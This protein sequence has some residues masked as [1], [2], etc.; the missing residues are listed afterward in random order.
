MEKEINSEMETV[1]FEAVYRRDTGLQK[2]QYPIEDLH[3]THLQPATDPKPETLHNI[4]PRSLL[5]PSQL[6]N[7]K[8]QNPK[9]LKP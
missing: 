6:Q 9:S 4:F 5:R 3:Y 8:P 7:P 1:F 2:F